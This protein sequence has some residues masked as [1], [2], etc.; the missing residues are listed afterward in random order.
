[1]V[2]MRSEKAIC[3]QPCLSEVSP[4]LPLKQYR[5]RRYSMTSWLVWLSLFN[6]ELSSDRYW[7]G[8]SLQEVDGERGRLWLTRRCHHQN[9]SC[10]QM[11]SDESCFNVS[12]AVRATNHFKTHTHTHTHTRTHTHKRTHTQTHTHKRTRAHTHT[13]THTHTHSHTHTHTHTHARTHARTHAHSLMHA[14][15]HAHTHGL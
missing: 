12:L 7:R 6:A 15:T 14:R 9:D 8:A 1:M 13:H 11:G 2:S 3:A 5:R 4:K 10:I